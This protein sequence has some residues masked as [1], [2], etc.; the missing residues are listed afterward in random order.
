MDEETL[1][2]PSNLQTHPL[3]IVLSHRKLGARRSRLC[4]P[5]SFFKAQCFAQTVTNQRVHKHSV[6]ACRVFLNSTKS[7][8]ERKKKKQSQILVVPL[9]QSFPRRLGWF[10]C[11]M[12]TASISWLSA[13]CTSAT[14]NRPFNK[15]WLT[16]QRSQGRSINLGLLLVKLRW[17]Q[18]FPCFHGL[19]MSA[20]MMS[21]P[22]SFK[23]LYRT[24]EKQAEEALMMKRPLQS[25]YSPKVS[26][27][28]PGEKGRD[29]RV[30]CNQLMRR[31]EKNSLHPSS[32]YKVHWQVRGL[33]LLAVLHLCKRLYSEVRR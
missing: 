30:G 11:V 17:N 26:E 21:N 1:P 25:W 2:M 23:H 14:V 9:P 3:K 10:C 27:L 5:N 18:N 20:L 33:I 16:D 22:P 4:A 15:I 29:W 12:E 8:Q 31:G 28:F 32:V 6:F 13:Y 7:A 24:V 19:C